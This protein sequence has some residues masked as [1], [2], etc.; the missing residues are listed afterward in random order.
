MNRD[1]G[2]LIE[3]HRGTLRRAALKLCRGDSPTA[4]DMVQ[5][6]YCKA[7]RHARRFSPGTNL[8]AWLMRILRNTVISLF[9]RRQ[10]AREVP[11]P[12]GLEPGRLG[13]ADPGGGEI[14]DEMA[15]ALGG[16]PE[17][18]RKAF[19][20]AALEDS[21][22]KEIAHRLGIPVGTVMS[23]LWRARRELQRRLSPGML[24]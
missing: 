6:T 18:H 19:L 2:S 1:F 7:I 10:V 20:M 15:R 16:L 21:P 13:P 4:D 14:G 23:R 8:R 3:L 12:E 11:Y 24:N 17:G 22:Y 5:E 9:R